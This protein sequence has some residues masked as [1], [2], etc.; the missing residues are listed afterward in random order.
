MSKPIEYV[1]TFVAGQGGAIDDALISRITEDAGLIE[2]RRDWLAPSVAADIF[3][4]DAADALFARRASVHAAHDCYALDVIVQP[5]AGRR[6]QLLVSDMDSTMI[7]QECID[8]LAASVGLGARISAITERAM[9]GE[10]VF[11]EALKERV[12]LLAGVGLS[13]IESLLSKITLMPGART[14]VQTMRRHGARAAMVTGGF[15]QFTEPVAARIGFDETFGNRLEIV[16][17]RLSGAVLPPIQGRAGKRAALVD[18][19]ARLGLSREATLAVGDGANDLDMLGEAGLGVAYHAKPKV[20]EA[21]H[22]RIDHADLT[23]L[24]Y[25]QGYRR[26]DFVE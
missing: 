12:K 9:Q 16:D 3:F 4:L 25:A 18:M 5:V 19:R 1:A 17:G 11:E 13:K 7:E 20:A 24:L 22:A 2:T 26:E 10:L 14:L 15:T 23:A 8:E 21:A 6:K